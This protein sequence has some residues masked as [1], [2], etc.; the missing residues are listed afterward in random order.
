LKP[1]GRVTEY[2][3]PILRAQDLLKD[4]QSLIE[5]ADW[6]ALRLIIDRIINLP[7]KLKTNLENSVAF[8][9]DEDLRRRGRGL[10]GEILEFV[11]EMDYNKYFEDRLN[12]K[13]FRG[14]DEEAQ[15]VEFSMKAAQTARM[16]LDQFLNLF[17]KSEI[18]SARNVITSVYD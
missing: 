1:K 9:E 5:E 4:S 17:P 11:Q 10:S 3:V 15:F 16:R 8:L 6:A 12:T 13:Q 14:G 18:I 2:L 7:N